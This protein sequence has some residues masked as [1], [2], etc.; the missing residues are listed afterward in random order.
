MEF[1]LIA[2]LPAIGIGILMFAFSFFYQETSYE[3]S[4]LILMFMYVASLNGIV[5]SIVAA[6]SLLFMLIIKE[7]VERWS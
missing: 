6:C 5:F 1:T 2:L 3:T 7:C 4:M